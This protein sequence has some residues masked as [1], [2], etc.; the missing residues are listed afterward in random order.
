[1]NVNTVNPRIS[2]LGAY[3]FL[4]FCM[5]AYSKGGLKLFQIVGHIPV[6]S[7]LLINY[8]FDGTHTSNRKFY[9]GQADCF[10]L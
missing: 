5:G 9:K 8:F 7:F 10:T 2:S 6:E 1:M 3:L 4:D